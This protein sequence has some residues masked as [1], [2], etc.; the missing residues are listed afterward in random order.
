ML[1]DGESLKATMIA[2]EIAAGKY[3]GNLNVTESSKT[4]TIVDLVLN[5][6]IPQRAIDYLKQ[7]AIVY[8]R[9]ANEDKNEIAVRTEQFIN[10]RL[11]KSTLNWVV[12]KV[13]WKITRNVTTWLS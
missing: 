8:N 6:E 3:V 7:L 10:Q 5:D 4:T 12:Q 11:E 9:Q 2:P 13:S 1:Q